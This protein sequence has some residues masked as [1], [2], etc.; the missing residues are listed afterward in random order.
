VAQVGSDCFS[1][2]TLGGVS[3]K[4]VGTRLPFR[5]VPEHE[6]SFS[7]AQ[8]T[9]KGLTGDD[10]RSVLRSSA[11]PLSNVPAPDFGAGSGN[12]SKRFVVIG[13]GGSVTTGGRFDDEKQQ[14]DREF[15]WSDCGFCVPGQY[16]L[17]RCT[18]RS[19]CTA[20]FEDQIAS[21][22]LPVRHRSVVSSGFAFD[23][24]C[25]L[26]PCGVIRDSTDAQ[27][28][29]PGPGFVGDVCLEHDSPLEMYRQ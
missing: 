19:K 21:S 14:A 13:P 15:V 3:C 2:E 4:A 10:G 25:R 20:R 8:A 27:G 23:L 18:S 17:R 11:V 29:L 16:G 5:V 24:F 12:D 28:A 1:D 6:C 22:L 7:K 26:T 9:T